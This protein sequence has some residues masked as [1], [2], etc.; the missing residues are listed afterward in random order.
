MGDSRQVAVSFLRPVLGVSSSG[1]G[2]VVV[3][4]VDVTGRLEAPG[5]SERM[6]VHIMTVTLVKSPDALSAAT[7]VSAWAAV[8]TM[9]MS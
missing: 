1:A 9:V 5:I 6:A 3:P 7:N 2:V 4:Q 8:P